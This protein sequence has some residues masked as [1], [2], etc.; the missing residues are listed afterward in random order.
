M[1]DVAGT[2]AA[3]GSQ[4]G[5][6]CSI[7]ARLRSLR[8]AMR[9]LLVTHVAGTRAARGSQRGGHCSIFA[10]L[11]SL[12]AAMRRL[13]GAAAAQRERAAS[14]RQQ[15]ERDGL[16][17]GRAELPTQR[18]GWVHRVVQVHIEVGRIGE[19]RGEIRID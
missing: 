3:R 9:R 8:A 13:L 17:D 11:R 2:R 15:R 7:F 1:T 10:R 19:H 4:H 6:H 18:A 16:R 12:R 14:E 5:G